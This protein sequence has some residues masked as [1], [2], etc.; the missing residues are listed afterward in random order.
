MP[1]SVPKSP[2]AGLNHAQ[3][4]KLIKSLEKDANDTPVERGRVKVLFPKQGKRLSYYEWACL[5]GRVELVR[6]FHQKDILPKD[7]GQLGFFIACSSGH[8]QVVFDQIAYGVNPLANHQ[9]ALYFA[10][11]SGNLTLVKALLVMDVGF[12]VRMNQDQCLK[13]AMSEGHASIVDYLQSIAQ[14]DPIELTR[15]VLFRLTRLKQVSGVRAIAE[16]L[17][18]DH[19][20][21]GGPLV[22][23]DLFEYALCHCPKI[24]R[25]FLKIEP[26]LDQYPKL[27]SLI[28]ALDAQVRTDIACYETNTRLLSQW[29]LSNELTR[30]ICF[31]HTKTLLTREESYA[32]LRQAERLMTQSEIADSESIS[33]LESLCDAFRALSI[34]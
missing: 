8:E 27:E 19:G 23:P 16:M 12:H 29:G 33:E 14:A 30:K 34:S 7:K 11:G 31:M 18:R 2:F 9:M 22:T 20:R 6:F 15:A 28:Q 26:S 1:S 25:Y 5:E 10:C 13:I 24:A 3:I 21:E 32:H 4:I 17:N